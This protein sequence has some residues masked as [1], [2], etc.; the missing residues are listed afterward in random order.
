LFFLYNNLNKNFFP[1]NKYII[2][3]KD[4]IFKFRFKFS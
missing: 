2:N 1:L 4:L 3:I